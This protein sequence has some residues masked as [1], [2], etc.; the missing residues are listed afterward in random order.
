MALLDLGI[1]NLPTML[2]F[3]RGSLCEA[4][5]ICAIAA[6]KNK[7]DFQ[8]FDERIFMAACRP[9]DQLKGVTPERVASVSWANSTQQKKRAPNSDL[10][11]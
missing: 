8:F 11:A 1:Q 9:H 3:G 2:L 7:S 6:K 4:T 5:V 10:C